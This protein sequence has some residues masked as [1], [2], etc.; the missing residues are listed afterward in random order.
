MGVATAPSGPASDSDRTGPGRAH[1]LRVARETADD[2]ATD[3]VAREQAGKAPFDEVS[4]LR[5]SGLLTLL[6]P[7]ELG[8]GGADWPTAYAVVRE[9]AAADGAIGQLLGCHYF[10]SWSAR[11]FT[12]PSLAAQVERQSAAEQW[13]W[14]GGFARQEPPLTLARTAAG[15][16][17]DGRQSY[18]TGVLVADRLAVRAV[19]ADTGEPLAVVVDPAH[20]GVGID[21]DADT[22]GQRLAAGGSVEFD[23][24]PVAADD[25]LGSLSADEDVLSPLAALASPVGR[26]LSVQLRLG[27]A[28]GVLAEARD[29]SRAGHSPWHPDWPVGSPQDP[30]VLT[31][32]GELTVLTRAASALTDQAEAAVHDGLVHG[33]DITYDEYAEISVLVAMAEAAASRAAQES[34]A[35]ALDIIGARSASSRLGFDRF[36]RN[37][38]THTLYE[39]VAHRLRDVGDYFLNGAHPPFVL[40]V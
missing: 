18:T 25:V 7:A 3:A 32:Y 37:A 15:F 29:Y 28:E 12:E 1:W 33:E 8:G 30:Q 5:E 19:R 4:R 35:R 22:F 40:P 38:R 11:F 13:C 17:L 34:T 14:G 36:W 21:G 16:V 23:G 9:I 6:I 24:V 27:M 26:L 39:P 2:L 10:L 20:H 31:A